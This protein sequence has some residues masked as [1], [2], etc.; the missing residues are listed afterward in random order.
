MYKAPE[1]L[2]RMFR[3][4]GEMNTIEDK[5]KYLCYIQ[6]LIG[7]IRWNCISIKMYWAGPI[8]YWYANND[9][10]KTN[11]RKIDKSM[12]FFLLLAFVIRSKW[13][14]QI[15]WNVWLTI[16]ICLK[17]FFFLPHPASMNIISVSRR[18]LKKKYRD[19]S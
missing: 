1:G 13:S 18:L 11:R 12:E 14:G 2:K 6:H 16:P 8:S 5:F 10:K 7:S 17:V 15:V 3:K 19:I 9:E 4:T